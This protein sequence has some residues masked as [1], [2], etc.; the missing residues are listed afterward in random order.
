MVLHLKVRKSRSPPGPH[1]PSLPFNASLAHSRWSIEYDAHAGGAVEQPFQVKAHELV[2]AAQ[3]EQRSKCRH[4]ARFSRFELAKGGQVGPG[5]LS[6]VFFLGERLEGSQR[7]AA[8][9]Q[10][11]IA[12]R[13]AGKTG[14]AG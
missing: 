1:P 9:A 14:E 6:I 4:C 2:V 12:N 10:E 3:T 13:P 11:Q 5:C 8:P 7:F